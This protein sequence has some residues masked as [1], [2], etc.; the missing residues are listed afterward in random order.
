MQTCLQQQQ[1]QHQT[2]DI[3]LEE[4][5]IKFQTEYMKQNQP[6]IYKLTMEM[7]GEKQSCCRG[8][9]FS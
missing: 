7:D 5:A 3:K 8:K 9:D 2:K 6:T 1:Q 4:R